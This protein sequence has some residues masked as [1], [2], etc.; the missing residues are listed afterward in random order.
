MKYLAVA[1]FT[2]L[3]QFSSVAQSCPA[4]CNPMNH[5]TPGLPLEYDIYFSLSS[6]CIIDSRSIHLL[7]LTQ[8]RPFWWLSNV[9]LGICTTTSLSIHL[10]MDMR[11]SEL[12]ELMMDRESWH[13]AIHGVAKNQTRLSDWTELMTSHRGWPHWELNLGSLVSTT[14][15]FKYN[16]KLLYK[17]EIMLYF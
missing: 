3:I 15:V 17:I 9:P 1:Q 11:L 12:Q 16:I 5:S 6:L 2:P 14:K 13:A 10:S 8:R 4:L 7:E